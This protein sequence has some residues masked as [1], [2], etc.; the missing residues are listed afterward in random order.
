MKKSTPVAAAALGLSVALLAGCSGNAADSRSAAPAST[1]GLLTTTDPASGALTTLRWGI[2]AQLPTLDPAR[3]VARGAGQV[4]ANMCDS[5]LLVNPDYSVSDNLA[6][7]T[8]EGDNTI[9][10]TLR[11]ATFWDGTP[12]T[13]DDVVY[14]LTRVLDPAVGSDWA[15]YF[16]DVESITARDGKTV[17]IAM[18][19]PDALFEKALGTPAGAVMQ[20]AFSEQAGDSLGSLQGGVMCSGPFAFSASDAGSI[21]LK[22]NDTYWNDER[23]PHAETLVVDYLVDGATANAALTA[24]EV[25]G[26]YNFPANATTA[27][28]SSTTGAVYLGQSTSQFAYVMGNMPDSPLADTRLRK[29]LSLAMDRTSVATKVFGASGTPATSFFGSAIA[30]QLGG[31]AATLPAGPDLDAAKALVDEVVAEKGAQR[32]L[33][34]SYTSGVGPE[35][36]QMMTYLEQVAGQ[37][38]LQVELLDEAPNVWYDRILAAPT[39][40]SFDVT[41]SYG[42]PT[43]ADPAAVLID[44]VPGARGNYSDFT[45]P[46]ID[47]ALSTGRASNDPAERDALAIAAGAALA[48]GLPKIP[49]VNV[50]N[51]LYMN[52]R[53]SG[54]PAS[55]VA[56]GFPW[57]AVVGGR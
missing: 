14:S 10:L 12:V 42:G 56:N 38:G 4:I 1:D 6:Q 15:P 31:D 18:K 28:T 57:A 13:A 43:L 7:L 25:D 52:D 9:V 16:T 27:L 17:Q 8:R 36:G 24:G 3:S 44:Y 22:R 26:M 19:S 35:V 20:R 45:A 53:V 2:N 23:R 39:S 34:F 49:A 41:F 54:A 33:I 47:E 51:L 29:A 55:A 48:E 32:P 30:N 40:P 46:A 50:A 11:D 37:I 21:T 5:L